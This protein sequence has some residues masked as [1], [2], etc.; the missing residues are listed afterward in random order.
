MTWTVVGREAIKKDILRVAK[1]FGIKIDN[2]IPYKE[3]IKNKDL[4]D[5]F[6]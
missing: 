1:E 4:N 5:Y 2:D 3:K 6:P